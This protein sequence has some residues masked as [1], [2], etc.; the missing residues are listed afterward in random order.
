MALPLLSLS[1]SLIVFA[2]LGLV[3]N[4]GRVSVE[5][6][7]QSRVCDSAL[8]RAKGL[9]HCFAVA[10]GLLIFSITAAVGDRVFPSTIF[11]SFAVVLLIGVSCLALGVVQQNGES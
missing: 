3:Y 9:M 8:G 6:I 5:G 7:L 10:L 11:F 2:A 1:W 4:L